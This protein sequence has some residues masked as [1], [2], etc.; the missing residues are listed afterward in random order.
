MKKFEDKI[1]FNNITLPA[2][3]AIALHDDDIWQPIHGLKIDKEE[4]E[5]VALIRKL[6]PLH[7]LN[8][9]AQ[10]LAFLLILCDNIQDWG[11]HYK[12]EKME[13]GLEEANI[14]LKDL[15]F[16]SGSIIIQI[17][18]TNTGESRKF[19]GHKEGVLKKIEKL[20][21]SLDIKFVIEYWDR[22]KNSLSDY[23]FTIGIEN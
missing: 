6:A 4:E 5:R 3:V 21:D 11:R 9:E 22:E 1:D 15:Y 19:M 2:A 18:F 23:K 16:D 20:L 12:D 8:F 14:R 10:P 13:K 7:R 17:Y